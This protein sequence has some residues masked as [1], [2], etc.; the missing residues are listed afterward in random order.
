MASLEAQ[1]ASGTRYDGAYLKLAYPGGDV[2][3]DQGVCTDVVIRAYRAAGYDLQQLV[4]E[5][6]KADIRRYPRIGSADKLDPNIDHRR[7]PNLVAYLEAHADEPSDWE[8]GDI[9]FWKLPGN[10]DHVGMVGTRA[11]ADGTPL[12]IH[13]IPNNIREDNAL[14]AWPMAGHYRWKPWQKKSSDR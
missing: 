12:M 11:A 9:V 14:L 6:A 7:C 5:D 1:V 8:P 10:R 4:Y 3:A 2:P 13:N